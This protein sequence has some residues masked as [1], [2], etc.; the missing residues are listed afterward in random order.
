MAA[1]M[2]MN[3]NSLPIALMQSLVITVPHLKW[4]DDDN[5]DAKLGRALSYLVVYSTLGMMVCLIL[6]QQLTLTIADDIQL[7]WS[8]GVKLLA[9][10]DAETI[11]QLPNIEI[12][13][14]LEPPQSSQ[15]NAEQTATLYQRPAHIGEDSSLSGEEDG[16]TVFERPNASQ[17]RH[18][19]NV[20]HFYYSFPN[21]PNNSQRGFRPGH[22]SPTPNTSDSDQSDLSSDDELP[23]ARPPAARRRHREPIAPTSTRFQSFLRRTRHRISRIWA[24]LNEFMTVPLWAGL[25]SLLVACVQPLQH[26]MDVHMPAAKGAL[27]AAG[28]CSIPVTL[29]VLGAYFYPPP[30]DPSEVE[31]RPVVITTRPSSSSLMLNMKKLL[32]NVRGGGE[33]SAE[34]NRRPG[35][36]AT[37]VIA[38]LSR[39][40]I[41]PLLLLPMMALLMK[42][43]WQPVL[44][45]CVNVKFCRIIH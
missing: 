34:Q 11:V 1:S 41:T 18:A 29:I 30:Q 6:A 17:P 3:S 40:I 39:M 5:K 33:A 38:V 23:S 8:Y 15:Q 9:S 22:F 10:A 44:E 7:R 25:A 27:S 4:G 45:E 12:S 42:F 21:S 24:T 31:R 13:R 37:V 16:N 36:T 35:E 28:N 43:N 2:F 26:A 20:D 14:L 19:H 32:L